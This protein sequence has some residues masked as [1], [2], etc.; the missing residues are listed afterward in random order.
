MKTIALP[1]Y[2]K[3]AVTCDVL[4]RFTNKLFRSTHN[5]DHI[6][7]TLDQITE[8]IWSKVDNY[9]KEHNHAQVS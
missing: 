3:P 8:K 7:K 6:H 9:Y 1:W 2:M 4:N 5:L